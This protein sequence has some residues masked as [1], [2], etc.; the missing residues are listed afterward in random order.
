VI[1]VGDSV[2][3]QIFDAFTCRLFWYGLKLSP[4]TRHTHTHTRTPLDALLESNKY[5]AYGLCYAT[6]TET[7]TVCHV[8]SYGSVLG[9]V[10]H[11]LHNG[12]L[13][14]GDMLVLNEGIH[15]RRARY[16]VDTELARIGQSLLS[17]DELQALRDLRVHL[18][19][20]E[21][22]AQHF[23]TPDGTFE[24][25][26]KLRQCKPIHDQSFVLQRNVAVNAA[27]QD[28]GLRIIPALQPTIAAFTSH[29][30][31]AKGG[32]VD[33]LHFCF[34]SMI[35][36]HVADLVLRAVQGVLQETYQ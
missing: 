15:F 4:L 30:A 21:T 9:W 33:C 23:D 6:D 2:S 3:G 18:F 17:N 27:L 20:R 16:H 11:M 5:S 32:V 35:L 14:R 25:V 24:G 28:Q 13:Q 31:K 26:Q 1:I 8:R 19:W 34:S 12:D 10:S 22:M 36:H 7:L 29:T